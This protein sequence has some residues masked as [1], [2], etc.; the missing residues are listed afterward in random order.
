MS[1]ISFIATCNL[2]NG[3]SCCDCVEMGLVLLV[4]SFSSQLSND[5][6]DRTVAGLLLLI[7]AFSASVVCDPFS[8]SAPAATKW[9]CVL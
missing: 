8:S 4:S 3:S 6:F 1:L 9:L 5:A 2:V 7:S